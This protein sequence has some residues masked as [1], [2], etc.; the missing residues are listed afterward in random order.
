MK[1]AGCFNGTK[2]CQKMCDPFNVFF[3]CDSVNNVYFKQ[4]N[5]IGTCI[6]I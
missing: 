2:T 4:E 6:Y 5:V 1:I 3:F